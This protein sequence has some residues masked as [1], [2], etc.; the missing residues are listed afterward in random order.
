MSDVEEHICR[1]CNT[2]FLV[3]RSEENRNARI[4]ICQICKNTDDREERKFNILLNDE[5]YPYMDE[6]GHIITESDPHEYRKSLGQVNEIHIDKEH[7]NRGNHEDLYGPVFLYNNNGFFTVAGF[8][9]NI[10]YEIPKQDLLN[11]RSVYEIAEKYLDRDIEYTVLED[12]EYI[13]D[14]RSLTETRRIW[15]LKH[16]AIRMRVQLLWT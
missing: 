11:Q 14:D 3:F 12:L 8:I 2:P 6:Y 1:S 10:Y 4:V 5:K 16:E 15:K 13:N 9:L 7:W